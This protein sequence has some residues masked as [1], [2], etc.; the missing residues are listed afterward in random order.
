MMKIAHTR[1]AATDKFL[2]PIFYKPNGS[3][4]EQYNSAAK[5]ELARAFDTIVDNRDN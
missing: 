4:N 3:Y 2:F 1:S 5:V